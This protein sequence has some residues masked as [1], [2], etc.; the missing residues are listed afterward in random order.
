M[1]FLDVLA[2]ANRNLMRSKLRTLLTIL[3]IFIGGFT[4]TLTT[5]LNTGANQYLERQ[6]GNVAVPGVFEV[7]PKTEENPFSGG[8]ELK[9]YDPDK[10]TA[11]LSSFYNATMTQGDVDKLKKVEGIASVVPLYQVTPEYITRNDG[12]KYALSQLQQDFGLNLDLASGRLIKNEDS[13]SMV[14]PQKYLEPLGLT[15]QDAPGTKVTVA[16]KDGTGA[17]VERELTVVGVMREAIVTAG[18]VYIDV[19]TAKTIAQAQGQTGRFIQLFASFKDVN[20]TTDESVLKKRLEA[21]GSYTA[22]SF[23]ESIG[24]LTS[25]VSAIT[26]AL[27]IIGI[28]ALVAASFGIINTLLM[29][30]YERTQEIGLMKALGMRRSKVFALFAIEAALVGF[31]GSAVAVGAAFGASNLVNDYAA[32]NFLKDFEGFTLLVVDPSGA[33]FVVGLIMLIAFVAGTLP[34]LKASRL[35]PIEALRSE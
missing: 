26:A 10:K 20:D 5:A 2:T 3:A 7:T 30:V 25:V 8:A 11:S 17:L 15:V 14:L 27:N 31:W 23:K 4:L 6:L 33:L 1:K 28:I 16:Y 12:K 18:A 24:T 13:A 19:T 9:E 22:T 34:A 29:S 21:A 35:N 32:A